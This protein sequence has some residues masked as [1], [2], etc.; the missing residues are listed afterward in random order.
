MATWKTFTAMIA[1]TEIEL[2]LL[3]QNAA[4]VGWVVRRSCNVWQAFRSPY[5]D[6]DV[7]D[8]ENDGDFVGIFPSGDDARRAV[9]EA[10]G[11]PETTPFE[12]VRQ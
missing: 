3:E 5:R 8:L 2:D 6:A 10:L 4:T 11:L 9:L 1:N 7:L 12:P